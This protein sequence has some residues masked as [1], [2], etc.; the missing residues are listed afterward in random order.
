MFLANLLNGNSRILF[1]CR[2]RFEMAVRILNR[3]NMCLLGRWEYCQNIMCVIHL[4]MRI[5]RVL[6]HSLAVYGS[7]LKLI[8]DSRDLTRKNGVHWLFI[9]R[10]YCCC[11]FNGHC[12]R[13]GNDKM[14]SR[15]LF[16]LFYLLLFIWINVYGARVQYGNTI[17]S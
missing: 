9:P 1:R 13:D 7:T 10:R 11:T 6:N 14:L 15:I 2:C 3:C 5:R 8:W 4:N 12:V 17:L 16:V